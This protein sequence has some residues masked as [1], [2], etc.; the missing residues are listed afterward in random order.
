M[1]YP[2]GESLRHM[3]TMSQLNRRTYAETNN[4]RIWLEDINEQL[5]VHVTIYNS[6]KS[7]INQIKE[8][9]AELMID[10]YFQGY[11]DVFTY[12]KDNRIIKMIGGA[13]KIGQ[14][15]DYEVWKWELRQ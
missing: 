3:G 11:E 13:S 1:G 8:G 15:E 6:N 4:Y 7:V 2:S 5:F 9:W 12:T 10:A 14:H